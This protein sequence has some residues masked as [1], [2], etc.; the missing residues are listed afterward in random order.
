[1]NCART[2]CDAHIFGRFDLEPQR[3]AKKRQRRVE[4]L[5]GDARHDPERPSCSSRAIIRTPHQFA[6]GG[7]GIDRSARRCDRQASSISA[8][9]H[10]RFDLPQAASATD[11]AQLE[12]RL[13][14]AAVD[15]DDRL[16]ARGIA[17]SRR[18]A[19]RTRARSVACVR[20]IGGRH[21]PSADTR[22]GSAA[23]RRRPPFDRRP[24]DRP[25]SRQRYRRSPSRRP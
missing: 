3:V 20:T 13:A 4:I 10:A 15:V 9:E 24:R 1:M 14:G 8:G 18:S 17:R 23:T 21:S 22:A 5:D 19:R 7:V 12:P 25:C 16:S 11:R 6:R 2:R